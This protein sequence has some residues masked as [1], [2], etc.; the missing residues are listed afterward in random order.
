MSRRAQVASNHFQVDVTDRSRLL[1]CLRQ[2]RPTHIIHLAA[3]SNPTKADA[4]RPLA[5]ATNTEAVETLTS[6]CEEHG[7]RLIFTS[8]DFV[9]R[10]DLGRPYT[11]ADNPDPATVYGQ[12]KHVAEQLVSASG[13]IIVRL[14]LLRHCFN[15]SIPFELSP[16]MKNALKKG[17]LDAAWDEYRTPLCADDAAAAIVR[18]AFMETSPPMHF[19]DA[20]L[21]STA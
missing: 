18:L 21:R 10:G 6:Y 13:G 5:W 4:A 20:R 16:T 17:W 19:F 7:S 14:S 12:T 9:F 15:D 2:Y 11:E 1:A 8:T 3:L